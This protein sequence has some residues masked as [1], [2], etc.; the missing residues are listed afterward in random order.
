MTHPFHPLHGRK[1]A[2]ASQPAV[3]AIA[4]FEI[5]GIG[6]G[7]RDARSAEDNLG[8][9][10]AGDV[11]GDGYGDFIAGAGG[12]GIDAGRA[13]VYAGSAAGLANTVTTT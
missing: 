10:F 1:R 2:G 5:V 13:Y 12:F 11:D 3:D 6:P 4:T 8:Y 9:A 7:Q